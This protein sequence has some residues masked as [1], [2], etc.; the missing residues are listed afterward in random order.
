MKTINDLKVYE[1]GNKNKQPILFI[2]GFPFSVEM[3]E[4]QIKYFQ[5]E[6]YCIAYDIRGLGKSDAGIGQFTMLTF[7]DDL[8]SIIETLSLKELIVC[9]LSM[10]GYITLSALERNQTLFKAAILCD[11]K[12]EADSDEVKFKRQINIK[13]IQNEGVRPFVIDFLPTTMNESSILLLGEKYNE[14]LNLWSSNN[15]IGVVGS[16]LA[17]LSRTDTTKILPAL[18]LPV[19]Y[20]CGKDDKI[21]PPEI[22]IEMK[23]KTKNS[24]IELIENAGHLSP[25]EQPKKVNEVISNFLK[26]IK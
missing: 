25:L 21:T 3:W 10:G 20:V 8:F 15:P 23:N 6:Y 18:S 11:T 5:E 13:R 7:T 12:S 9:G 2:H 14:L 24:R 19:L 26:E 17:M 1:Y 4:Y 16:L 22:M